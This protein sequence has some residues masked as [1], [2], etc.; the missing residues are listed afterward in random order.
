MSEK[1][2]IKAAVKK[3]Y[4]SL[5]TQR[6]IPWE[7][8]R[9][10]ET[11]SEKLLR[12]GYSQEQLNSLPESA[13]V[14]ADGCGNPT[15]LMMI[16]Q[17]ETLLDLGSGGG[18]DVLLASKKVGPRG[19]VIGLDMTPEM[20]DRARANAQKLDLANIE[21]KL[22]E[23]EHIPLDDG[24]VDVIMSNCVICLI[25]DKEMVFREMYRVLKQGGRLAIADELAIKPFSQEEKMDID[26]WCSCITGAITEA[27]YATALRNAGFEN[28]NVKRLHAASS[29]NVFS[30]FVTAVRP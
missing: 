3:G 17:G 20:I 10:G 11:K 6:T 27:E 29:P 15:G 22:G 23:I 21:F 25:P 2:Q 30:A 12:Y 16:K 28:I 19:K 1:E 7:E 24:T 14:T 5:A 26:R 8:P 13:V 9:G 4:A 18:I